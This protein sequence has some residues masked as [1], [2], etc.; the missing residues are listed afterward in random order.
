MND[1][2]R[3]HGEGYALRLPINYED[4]DVG[5]VVYYA[6]YL[7]YMERARNA[8]LR[9]LGFPLTVLAERHQALFVVT[10]ARLR[11]LAPARLDD[12]IEVGVALRRLRR[13]SLEFVQQVRRG[14]EILVQGEL[15][16]ATVHSQTFKPR[17]IPPP[18]E[19]AL[20]KFLSSRR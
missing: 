9:H 20:V 17:R 18:L 7:G 6:N 3:P 14:D 10:E 13:A 8:Y 16:L 11:Y 19:T 1:S 15:K 5:G 12:E 2:A 4:T